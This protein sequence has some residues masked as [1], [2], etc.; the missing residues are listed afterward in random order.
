MPLNEGVSLT[1][2][3]ILRAPTDEPEQL[4]RR[5]AL[6]SKI[7][8]LSQRI[9][10]TP[11]PAPSPEPP[12]VTP[13]VKPPPTE[14]DL[15]QRL[16]TFRKRLGGGAPV[17]TQVPVSKTEADFLTSFKSFMGTLIKQPTGAVQPIPEVPQAVAQPSKLGTAL[18]GI[19]QSLPISP[20]YWKPVTEELKA[21]VPLMKSVLT[22][23]VSRAQLNEEEAVQKKLK[24]RQITVDEA[25]TQITAIRAKYHPEAI[26]LDEKQL[27]A[28]NARLE[29]FGNQWV[30][31]TLALAALPSA[32]TMW[33]ATKTLPLVL[34][35]TTR[36]ILAPLLGAEKL[37]GLPLKGV[38][39]LVNVLTGKKALTQQATKI[40]ERAV[41]G[42]VIPEAELAQIPQEI[43]NPLRNILNQIKQQG[44]ELVTGETGGLKVPKP[45]E[46]PKVP[47][48]PVI[49]EVKP[50]IPGMPKDV[51][52]PEVADDTIRNFGKFIT[53]PASKEAWEATTALRQQSLGQRIGRLQ[54]RVEQ[55]VT[56]GKEAE[57]AIRQATEETMTGKYPYTVTAVGDITESVRQSLFSKVYYTLKDEPLE[58]ISTSEALKNALLGKP[59]P[60]KLGIAGKSAYTRLIR[61]FGKDSEVIKTLNK[62]RPLEEEIEAAL[63]KSKVPIPPDAEIVNYLRSL[64]DIPAKTIESVSTDPAIQAAVRQ[65]SLIP[66]ENQALIIRILKETGLTATDI[67]NFLRANKASFD[68]SFWRQQ[69]PLIMNNKKAFFD[70][71]IRGWQAM[72]S[73]KAA[74]AS[75]NGIT[76][77]P[78]YA[79][80]EKLNIDFLRPL[81]LPKGAPRWKGVEE[82]GYLQTPRLIPRLTEKIPWVKVSQ[83]GFV[84]GANEHNW[85]IFK[86]YY[87]TLIRLNEQIASG[88]VKAPKNFSIE[89][90]LKGLGTMLEDMSGR[91]QLGKAS[92]LAP[93]ANS[94]FFALR[95]N[96]GRLLSPRHLV[97]SDSLVRKE[98]WKNFS[99]FIGTVGSVTLLGKLLGI[100]DVEFDNRSAKFM[101]I[102]IGNTWIDPWGGYARFVVLASRL[103]RGTGI[104]ART[105]EEFPIKPL[106]SLTYFLRGSAAP[107]ASIMMDFWT[108]KTFIG[109]TVD[110][111]NPKQWMDRLAPFMIQDVYN[112]FEEDGLPIAGIA[113]LPGAVGAGITTIPL[114][115]LSS[116]WEDSLEEYDD[117]PSNPIEVKA[118]HILSRDQYRTR[119]PDIDAKLFILGRVSSVRTARAATVVEQIVRDSGIDPKT[120]QA[121]QDWQEAE[122]ERVKLGVRDTSITLTDRLIRNL[123]AGKLGVTPPSGETTD[124]A[125]EWEELRERISGGK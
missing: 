13:P 31:P 58:L 41:A 26:T 75:W 80:Y 43:A 100:W 44:R 12:L 21:E 86:N 24:A 7:R 90:S 110:V 93:A 103:I 61:V 73:Q 33:A 99:S 52:A 102:R 112:A 5:E 121:V 125:K 51:L 87:N 2:D 119:N 18:E 42:E 56:E 84:T 124:K 83:R 54:Q 117:I 114:S 49:P 63:L 46:V 109:E 32:A 9:Q 78:L 77:D 17:G 101:Q 34:K 16:A 95:Y 8:S 19:W 22:G 123:L 14:G 108:G 97:S 53:S 94:F 27:E 20:E 37:I 11:P 105:G 57:V 67:G 89:K 10:A 23:G 92:V 15:G 62:G 68:F 76:K 74:E 55:L 72:W 79:L 85:R 50:P 91:A 71:N 40:I 64:R 82:F 48:I 69:A 3:R 28:A 115:E 60:Q 66:L 65:R 4:A 106:E 120:I 1:L 104:S 98:A 45:G 39:E 29:E 25:G 116:I 30:L 96:L 118:K 81:K 88:K 47:R 59:I 122:A 6:L 70:A 36:T 111:K 38:N 35:V 107:L 113:F